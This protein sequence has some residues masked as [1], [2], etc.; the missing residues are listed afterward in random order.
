MKPS[1]VPRGSEE[2]DDSL[3]AESLPSFAPRWHERR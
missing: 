1:I 3:M 2:L